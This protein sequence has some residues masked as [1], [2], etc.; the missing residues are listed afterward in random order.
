[1]AKP[2]LAANR[3]RAK[4]W[5]RSPPS[6]TETATR[7]A[8]ADRTTPA[9]YWAN[10]STPYSAATGR[11]GRTTRAAPL[12][13]APASSARRWP[14]RSPN[15]PPVKFPA[16]RPMPPIPLITPAWVVERP[17]GPTR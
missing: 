13:Q 9:A 3:V 6:G 8:L 5:R 10:G 7:A 17:R 11:T 2:P 16:T 4:L 14:R 12:T 15:Q 1:M